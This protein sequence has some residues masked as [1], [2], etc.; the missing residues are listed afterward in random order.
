MK[1][2]RPQIQ[3][4]F[5]I[6]SR[7]TPF[8]FT[9]VDDHHSSNNHGLH[10]VLHNAKCLGQQTNQQQDQLA[11]IRLPKNL[12]SHSQFRQHRR[13]RCDRDVP[14]KAEGLQ[15]RAGTQC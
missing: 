4:S 12:H 15:E 8:C 2:I 9:A 6:S 10:L 7:L 11:S 3:T 13:K 1:T 5:A 14:N